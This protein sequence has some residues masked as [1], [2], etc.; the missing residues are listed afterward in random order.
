MAAIGVTLEEAENICPEGVVVACHNGVDSLT[1]SGK[2]DLVEKVVD[3]LKAKGK[4][5]KMV[6]SSGVPFHSPQMQAAEKFMYEKLSSVSH[7]QTT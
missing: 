3:E 6:N 7:M 5:A 1:I 2:T 4:F